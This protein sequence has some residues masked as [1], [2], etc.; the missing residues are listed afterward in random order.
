[1]ATRKRWAAGL[2]AAALAWTGPALATGFELR[3]QSA[4]GQGTSFAGVAARA[5]DPSMMFF[6]P[7]AM[8]GLAGIQ[9]VVVGNGIFPSA[10]AVTATGTRNALLGGSSI[11]GGTG[12]DIALSAFLPAGYATFELARDWRFGISATT[13]WGLVTKTPV[14]AV[15]RYHALTSS[16]RT[17]NIA[18]ALAWQV[19][20]TLSVGAALNIQIASARLSSAVDFG[21]VGAASGLAFRPG[22]NDGR[23]TA[24]GDNTEVGFQLGAQWEP[25]PGTRFGLSYRSQIVHHLRGDATFEAVPAPLSRSPNFANTG[26]TAKLPT[27]ATITLGAS[28]R[29][30]ERWTLLGGIEWTNWSAFKTLAINFDNGRPPSVSVEGWRNTVFLSAGGEYRWNE[31]LTLRGGIAWDQSPVTA[32]DR[33]PRIPDSDRFWLSAG[34]SYAVTERLILSGAY[35]HIFAPNASVTLTDP[36]PNNSNLFRGNLTSN[37]RLSADV[38]SA[39]LR[40]IF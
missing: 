26:V 27:P 15:S 35:T 31:K 2:A 23:S 32:E 40:V 20:P 3:E 12:G 21:A 17:Y 39:Q 7:A 18:P 19:T 24:T 13:P 36:G 38:V 29:I 1:M 28:Q 34:L 30:A 9:T 11:S 33:T 25:Q 22:G 8:A 5:D 6:N 16:L 4:L 14:D 10:T 37:Y